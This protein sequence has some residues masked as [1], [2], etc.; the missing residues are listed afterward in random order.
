MEVEHD[1][2]GLPYWVVIVLL[3]VTG[4][5]MPVRNE[6]RKC[7]VPMSLADGHLHVAATAYVPACNQ[8]LP[9][10]PLS[11]PSFLLN[12]LSTYLLRLHW[13]EHDAKLRSSHSPS[14]VSLFTVTAYE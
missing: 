2:L 11:N 6:Q 5:K 4:G 1:G 13:I 9:I 12:C 8:H 10:S 7:L 14:P 3:I